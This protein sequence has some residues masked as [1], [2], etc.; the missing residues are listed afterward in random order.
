M[1]GVTGWNVYQRVTLI[2]SLP[3][4]G[5]TLLHPAPRFGGGYEPRPPR[6]PFGA[7]LPAVLGSV[8]K[9]HPVLAAGSDGEP[10]GTPPLGSGPFGQAGL[11]AKFMITACP[12]MA[13]DTSVSVG[14]VWVAPVGST[15][16]EAR[17]AT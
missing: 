11:L 7:P 6:G 8:M 15:K 4:A 9:I 3:T 1:I 5:V 12:W 16:Y 13:L 14:Q 2:G 17:T 10:C